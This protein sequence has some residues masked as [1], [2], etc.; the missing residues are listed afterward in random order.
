VSKNLSLKI[1]T[2]QLNYMRRPHPDQCVL[3][4]TVKSGEGMGKIFAPT[5]E[6]VHGSK[7]QGKSWEWY[8][9][10]YLELMRER[11]TNHRHEFLAVLESGELVLCC[12]CRDTSTTIQHCH[13]YLLR[14]ILSKVA[15]TY[16]YDV[17]LLGE[18]K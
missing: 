9:G 11:Y 1:A 17:E 14:D 6:L 8:T 18:V 16:G 12:Y 5:K 4:T 13:R 7:Y 3:N 2:A 10:G 15:T